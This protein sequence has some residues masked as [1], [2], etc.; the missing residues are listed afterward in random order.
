VTVLKTSDIRPEAAR[1]RYEQLL[2]EE[3]ARLTGPDG[4]VRSDL[5]QTVSCPACRGSACRI[6]D[7]EGDTVYKECVACGCVYASPR[8]NAEALEDF[9]RHS[10]ALNYFHEQVLLPSEPTRR[11]HVFSQPMSLLRERMASGRVLELGSAVGTLL[12]MLR[13]SGY[14]PEGIELCDFSVRHNRSCGR[15]V[16]D[17]PIERLNLPADTY[18]AVVAW[19]VFSHLSDPRLTLTEVR[20]V[21]KPGG[22]LVLNAYNARSFEYLTLRTCYMNPLV[23]YQYYTPR[24]VQRL[25]NDA[26]F[27]DIQLATPGRTDV[28]TVTSILRSPSPELGHFLNEILFCECAEGNAFRQAFQDFIVNHQLSGNLVVSAAIPG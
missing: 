4:R 19:G 21:L 8:L 24:S 11:E 22:A 25:L 14:E 3:R 23:L 1:E 5:A 28:E 18:D 7:P 17:Q 15:T 26:G 13:E 12:E 9:V 2:A 16:H 6:D 27:V 20:R 10:A